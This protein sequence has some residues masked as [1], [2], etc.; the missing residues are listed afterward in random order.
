MAKKST[1][2]NEEM[3][4]TTEITENAEAKETELEAPVAATEKKPQKTT[5]KGRKKKETTG[6]TKT[7]ESAKKDTTSPLDETTQGED[8][9]EFVA[10]EDE[11]NNDLSY[12]EVDKALSE[13]ESE[14]TK[15]KESSEGD[16]FSDYSNVE[17]ISNFDSLSERVED[18][19]T[20]DLIDETED[21]NNDFV[22]DDVP[23]DEQ[24]SV[25]DDSFDQKSNIEND[26]AQQLYQSSFNS[27]KG[28]LSKTELW[29]I[30]KSLA[31]AGRT[32]RARVI[33]TT[34][35]RLR[36]KNGYEETECVVCK[37]EH[38]FNDFFVYIPY[39]GWFKDARE[40]RMMRDTLRGS[41]R[42]NANRNQLITEAISLYLNSVDIVSINSTYFD[43]DTEEHIIIASRSRALNNKEKYYFDRGVSYRGKIRKP[44]VGTIVHNCNI[45]FVKN[46]CI[47]LNVCGIPTRID[48]PELSWEE[49]TSAKNLFKKGDTTDV[50]ITEIKYRTLAGKKNIRIIRAS[51][52]RLTP[53]TTIAALDLAE[54]R[55]GKAGKVSGVITRIVDFEGTCRYYI[56]TDL[57]YRACARSRKVTDM[58]NDRD[59]FKTTTIPM[60]G[61]K[62]I[63]VPKTRKGNMMFGYFETE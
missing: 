42:N 25:D 36:F 23:E 31:R 12:E 53:D 5:A 27:N 21:E 4:E 55:L 60:V 26:M 14:E 49:T 62:V 41:F 52:K 24:L 33:A 13:I 61:D 45:L 19:E 56:Q 22:A 15:D 63:F 54:N 35:K 43:K 50:I 51:V 8:F 3:V 28:N 32:F 39:V 38:P 44:R 1:N 17:D 29:N 46:E 40:E 9:E 30:L 11:N 47:Y 20:K 34:Q 37:L 7:D 18:N 2:K 57:G 59:Y 48:K 58:M 6:D 10:P 16:D